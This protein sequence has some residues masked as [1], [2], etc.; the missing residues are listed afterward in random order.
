MQQ[1]QFPCDACGATGASHVEQR[2]ETWPVKGEPVAVSIAVRVCDHCGAR[3][4]DR[5]LDDAAFAQA[6]DAYRRKHNVISPAEIVRLREKYGLTQRGLAALLGM[7]EI[8]IHR[9]E[10]GSLPDDAH[11]TLLRLLEDPRTME[12]IFEMHSARLPASAA[13]KLRQRLD[14]QGSV[15]PVLM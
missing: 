10:K 15:S 8:T 3:V 12:T 14:H 9:Y 11:N 5:E 4:F 13:R 1:E 2:E 7:G 6:F